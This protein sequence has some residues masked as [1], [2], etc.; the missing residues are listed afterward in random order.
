M[1]EASTLS[2]D[3][4]DALR[5]LAQG[6]SPAS[7]ARGR[8]VPSSIVRGQITTACER[9]GVETAVEAVVLGVRSRWI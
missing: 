1:T 9:L 2:D 6:Q 7:I 3:E 8:G 4:L 5:L